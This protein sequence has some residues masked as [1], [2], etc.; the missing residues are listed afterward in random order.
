MAP[1][2]EPMSVGLILDRTFF[3]YRK[4]FVRFIAIVAVVQIPVGLFQ[5]LL[6]RSTGNPVEPS[7]PR[8]CPC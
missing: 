1:T 4:N 2:F 7:G 3:L 8:H 5:L 6:Q